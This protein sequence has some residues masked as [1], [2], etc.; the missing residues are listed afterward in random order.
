MDE[1]MVAERDLK[2]TN[3][4]HYILYRGMRPFNL[5][6]AHVKQPNSVNEFKT[7]IKKYTRST[8]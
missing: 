8:V 1:D 6:P 4:Q 5:L 2:L 7:N 3:T